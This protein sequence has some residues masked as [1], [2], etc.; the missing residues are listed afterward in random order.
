MRVGILRAGGPPADMESKLGSYP[1]MIRNALGKDFLYREYDLERGG[2]PAAAS[3]ADAYVIS[4]SA[5]SV[6]DTTPWIG[7]LGEWLR[8]LDAG[9]PV[10]G[11]CFGHQIMAQAFGGAVARASTGL[12]VGLHEYDVTA[13]EPWMDDVDRF[14]LP[15]SHYDQVTQPPEA[16]RLI[17]ANAFCP[18]AVLSYTDRRAISFQAH[19]EFPIEFV[20]MA[21]P[22]WQRRGLLGEAEVRRAIAS[23]RLPDHRAEV[24]EWIRRYLRGAG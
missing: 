3:E 14:V 22:R 8:R 4:G 6:Y 10:V 24:T 20:E 7:R 21:I 17:A 16:A 5:S 18:Y 1:Q 15:V 19:P 2:F 23:L 9:T 12:A 11:I 13:R